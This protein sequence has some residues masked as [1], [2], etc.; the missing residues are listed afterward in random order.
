MDVVK[1]LSI[2]NQDDGKGGL[3]LRGV[4]VTTYVLQ[5]THRKLLV[6]WNR[7]AEIARSSPPNRWLGRFKSHFEIARFVIWASVQ[8]ADS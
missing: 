7:G 8:I 3:S 5:I 4:A 6:F 2:K 1:T